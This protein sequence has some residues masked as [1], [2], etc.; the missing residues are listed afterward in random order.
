MIA[1]R[2]GG[3][4][5]LDLF[6]GSGAI[7]I[8][9][10]SRGAKSAAF[11]EKDRRALSVI[12]QNLSF[13]HLSGGGRVIAS[14]CVRAIA[15]LDHE[16]PF[17]IIFMDPPY[18]KGLERSVL[19]AISPTSVADEKTLIIVE[20]SLD[21]DFSYLDELGFTLVREKRYKTNKHV[22][23]SRSPNDAQ[24]HFCMGPTTCPSPGGIMLLR[25]MINAEQSEGAKPYKRKQS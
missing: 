17:D 24:H 16:H 4:R 15:M 12:R 8:E 19:E 10:L 7:G 11:V 1:D 13:T 25:S 9:A 14:D 18:D 20:A 3:C 21:T 5:F 6:A 22:F 23:L 2:I